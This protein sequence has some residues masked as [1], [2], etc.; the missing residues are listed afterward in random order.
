[1]RYAEKMQR[2]KRCVLATHF[3][4]IYG[5]ICLR[6]STLGLSNLG[7]WFSSSSLPS[8]YASFSSSSHPVFFTLAFFLSA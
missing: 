6:A 8:F 5:G 3:P 1:M 2:R 4:L 7:A